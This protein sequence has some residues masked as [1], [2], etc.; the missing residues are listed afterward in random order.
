MKPDNAFTAGL[1]GASACA[2]V[3]GVFV[4]AKAIFTGLTTAV[5]ISAAVTIGEFALFGFIAGA[6]IYLLVRP[7]KNPSKPSSRIGREP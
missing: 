3:Y 1:E 7:P 6:G 4:V 2:T 5:A